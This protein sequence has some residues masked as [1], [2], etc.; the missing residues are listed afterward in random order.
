MIHADLQNTV[1]TSQL[2]SQP[3]TKPAEMF[4]QL[5]ACT[6]NGRKEISRK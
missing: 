1:N 4:L 2:Y 6:F 5:S 3:E